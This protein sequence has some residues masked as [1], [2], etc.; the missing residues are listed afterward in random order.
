VECNQSAEALMLPAQLALSSANARV[1]DLC[2][3]KSVLLFDV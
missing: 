3:A 2:S 1:C